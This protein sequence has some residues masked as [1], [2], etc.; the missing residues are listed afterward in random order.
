MTIIQQASISTEYNE[1]NPKSLDCLLCAITQRYS[2]E[3]MNTIKIIDLASFYSSVD[4]EAKQSLVLNIA[5][6][7][8]SFLL[9][10]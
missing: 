4:L 7:L 9:F 6:I 8:G 10:Q 1:Y 2:S 5:A 3:V